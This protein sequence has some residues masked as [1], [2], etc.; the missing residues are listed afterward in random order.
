MKKRKLSQVGMCAHGH[1]L[2]AGWHGSDPTLL[3]TLR[4]ERA[5]LQNLGEQRCPQ[6]IL[7]QSPDEYT[8][9]KGIWVTCAQSHYQAV[10]E[11]TG[12]L[13]LDVYSDC[14]IR[15]TLENEHL[16]INRLPVRLWAW[17][18]HLLSRNVLKIVWGSVG[19]P[20]AFDFYRFMLGLSLTWCAYPLLLLFFKLTFYLEFVSRIQSRFHTGCY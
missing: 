17:F 9:A 12:I 15:L 7:P 11:L 8:Q 4:W 16:P 1:T 20:H 3:P 13:F 10:L 19:I 2:A 6:S 14:P 5:L 18:T